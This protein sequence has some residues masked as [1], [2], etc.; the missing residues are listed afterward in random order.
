MRDRE[1]RTETKKDFLSLLWIHLFLNFPL[2]FFLFS[3]FPPL[4][5]G[6]VSSSTHETFSIFDVFF[7]RFS[8]ILWAPF[9]LVFSSATQA[10]WNAPVSTTLKKE[11][12][13]TYVGHICTRAVGVWGQDVKKWEIGR[14]RLQRSGWENVLSTHGRSTLFLGSP[15]SQQPFLVLRQVCVKRGAQTSA[16]V[17]EAYMYPSSA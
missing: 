6:R 13:V 1:Q 14:G 8:E 12:G 15:R 16:W 5:W 10:K 2:H 4:R 3:K 17:R 7:V 11:N 9:V